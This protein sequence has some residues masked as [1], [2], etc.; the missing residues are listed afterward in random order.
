[1]SEW[2]DIST[3]P[4]DGTPVQVRWTMSGRKVARI[5]AYDTREFMNNWYEYKF[6]AGGEPM[7]GRAIWPWEW[8]YLPRLPAP[9][10]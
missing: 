2:Q 9:P 5:A 7:Q 8:R 10:A 3:A 6:Q 1:M 4:K